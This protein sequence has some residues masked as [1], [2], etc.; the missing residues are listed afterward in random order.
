MFLNKSS[1][2]NVLPSITH[3]ENEMNN[4]R[5]ATMRIERS[6]E[7]E[8]KVQ[9]R[10]LLLSARRDTFK[11]LALP[12]HEDEDLERRQNA[13]LIREQLEKVK[14]EKGNE[15]YLEWLERN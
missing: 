14:S 11:G 3:H 7:M 12:S 6:E 10:I 9:P 1:T 13:K 2:T 8:P 15:L 5:E 4:L